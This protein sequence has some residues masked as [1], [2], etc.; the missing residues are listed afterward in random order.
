MWKKTYKLFLLLL[1]LPLLGACG[2]KDRKTS[3]E[4][5]DPYRQ[6]HPVLRGRSLDIVYQIKNTG[7]HPLFITEILP[8]CGCILVDERSVQVIPVGDIGRLYL[9]YDSRKN[10]GPTQHYVTIVGNLE[11]EGGRYELMF[12]I[13][14][15]PHAL[16][17]RDYEELYDPEENKQ[18][19]GWDQL[20]TADYTTLRE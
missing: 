13:L 14:V 20:N 7:E 8:S 5:I 9:K 19:P 2:I 11:N 3:I 1:L 6:Y 17:T 16:Y 4:V 18:K 10:V 15:V 12:E